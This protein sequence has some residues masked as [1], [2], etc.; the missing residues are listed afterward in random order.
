MTTRTRQLTRELTSDRVTVMLEKQKNG[1]ANKLLVL[2]LLGIFAAALIFY[3]LNKPALAA[4]LP[5]P[6]TLQKSSSSRSPTTISA[7]EEQW[8][9]ELEGMQ[10]KYQVERASRQALE[11]QMLALDVQIKEMQTELDFFRSNNGQ[12]NQAKAAGSANAKR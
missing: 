6:S 12:T 3:L 1:L 4:W 8:R 11:K 5:H 9:V 7:K 10:I 2:L